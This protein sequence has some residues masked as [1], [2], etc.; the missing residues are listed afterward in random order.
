MSEARGAAATPSKSAMTRD[1]R[2]WAW[3]VLAFAA[4]MPIV[5][6]ALYSY[7]V[8]SESVRK[9]VRENNESAAKITAVLLKRELDRSVS[10]A[11]TLATL[12]GTI[13]IVERRDEE[14]MRNRLKAVV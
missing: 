7:R 2:A 14:A 9:L 5:A 4:M 12:P 10:F 8:A 1:M 3:R 11:Q 13:D 6:L